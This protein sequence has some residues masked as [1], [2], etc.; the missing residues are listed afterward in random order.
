MNVSDQSTFCV[1]KDANGKWRWTGIT[2]TAYRDRDQEHVSVKSQLADAARMDEEGRYGV[3]RWWH[4]GRPDPAAWA[5][6][7]GEPW[8]PGIDLGACDFS[9]ALGPYRIE[10]GTFLSE[11]VGAA[12]AAAQ[13]SLAF[14]IGFHFAEADLIDGTFHAHKTFERSLLPT[15]AASNLLTTLVVSQKEERMATNAE[16]LQA[17]EQLI[18][19]DAMSAVLSAAADKAVLA[20]RLEL[21]RKEKLEEGAKM[22]KPKKRD[23]EEEDEE[24][25]PMKK[26]EAD[27]FLL[28]IKETLGESM[29]GVTDKIDGVTTVVKANT[30]AIA[31]I[32]NRLKAL[33]GEQPRGASYRHS[34][35]GAEPDEALKGKQPAEDKPLMKLWIPAEGG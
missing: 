6:K 13:E 9:W 25:M 10:S 34:Q 19:P 27:A 21:S 28:S 17:L 15:K 26:K 16:K 8:G 29:K 35:K 31:D 14:S 7:E 33:E 30:D 11:T 20:D 4:V 2:S 24:D 32:D 12:V 18:G 1:V 23:E 22:D 3:L 5:T